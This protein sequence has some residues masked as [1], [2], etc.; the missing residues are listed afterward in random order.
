MAATRNIAGYGWVP[1][2]PDL[3]DAR[4]QV[5]P[6]TALPAS[7]D[8]TSRPDMPPVYDQGRL[9]SCTGNAIAGAVDFDNHRQQGSFLAPSRLWVYYQE[10]VIE[11]TVGQDAGGQIRDGIKSVANLGV[12]PES[13]WPY[14]IATFAKAPPAKDYTDALGD[15]ALVYQAVTQDLWALKSVLAAGTP[16][17]FGF[18]VYDEFE[19]PA[20]ASSGIVPMPGSTS[21]VVGGHAVVLVGYN[22]AVDRFRV[23]NSWGTTWGQAG[24]FELP[25]LYVTSGSLASDFWV[26]Q[27]TSVGQA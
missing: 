13:D 21:T 20:V 24:Y 16:V 10:R 2:L 12:C 23:R 25:Y 6:V 3:R 1:Q 14:D 4:L 11:G 19:S 26:V 22:D 15:R 9:G 18:T 8:L 27:Q 5:A 7:V 17:V